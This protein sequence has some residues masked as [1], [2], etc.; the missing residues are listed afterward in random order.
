MTVCLRVA[1]H[2]L[3]SLPPAVSLSHR[4]ERQWRGG[5]GDEGKERARALVCLC[6]RNLCVRVHADRYLAERNE[7]LIVE[8][9][10][11]ARLV[12][13]GAYFNQP[14]DLFAQLQVCKEIEV[15][16]AGAT[17]ADHT[18][19]SQNGLARMRRCNLMWAISR[20]RAVTHARTVW[21]CISRARGT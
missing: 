18:H 12:R 20:A 9:D 6:V 4:R 1:W 17:V 15:L 8:L 3:L 21:R 10:E 16:A 2:W 14:V 19:S 11:V 5:E 13:G 7:V